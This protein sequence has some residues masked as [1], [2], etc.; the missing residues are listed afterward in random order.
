MI[1]TFEKE[2]LQLDND[3]MFTGNSLQH[4]CHG[5]L[6]YGNSHVTCV[7]PKHRSNPEGP[8]II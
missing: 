4:R 8:V 1:S 7:F 2:L 3:A 6:L 5:N